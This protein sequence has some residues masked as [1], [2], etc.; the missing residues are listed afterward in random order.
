[1]KRIILFFV[2]LSIIYTS[3]AQDSTKVKVMNKNVVTVV[4]DSTG[5]RVKVGDKNGVEITTDDKGDTTRIRV[6]RRIFDVIEDN[7]GTEINI[8]RETR[9]RKRDNPHFN[10]H[11]AGVELGMNMFHQTDYSPY[12]NSL[13]ADD[14]FF[15]LNYGKSL[16]VNINF[17]ELTFK[18]DRN[19]VGLV[20]G[21]GLSLMDFRF[22]RKIT[23]IKDD[24]LGKIIPDAL[25]PEGLKKTKL[26]VSYL[27]LPLFLEVATPL[28]FNS[29]RLTLAAGVIGGIII[30]AHTK[31]KYSGSKDKE[32]GNFNISPLKYELTGRIGL[33]EFCLFANYG[34]T[35]L[36]KDGKGPKLMP[37]EV[38]ISFPNI[39]F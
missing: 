19:T 20:T 14:E 24:F 25:N 27:T 9:E 8:T 2:A 11:W 30:G 16:T 36:F 15:D 12:N 34:M 22:D 18:N 26:H 10:G 17:A 21:M 33:G 38:G 4:E 28:K 35:P 1:M 23:I 7:D 37:L 5:T 13:Y 31:I 6:G 3:G 39:R 29:N 32:R